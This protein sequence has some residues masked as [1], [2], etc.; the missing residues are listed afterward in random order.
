MIVRRELRVILPQSRCRSST[1]EE[2][3][4]LLEKPIAQ[5]AKHLHISDPQWV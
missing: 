4:R 5:I 2:L 3:A 1:A